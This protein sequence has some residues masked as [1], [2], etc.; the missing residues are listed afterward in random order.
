[1]PSVPNPV[2]AT[3]APEVQD[4][5][6]RSGGQSDVTPPSVKCP[7]KLRT[8]FM[9]P[10]KVRKDESTLPSLGFEPR[11]C[12]QEARCSNPVKADSLFLLQLTLSVMMAIQWLIPIS[13]RFFSTWSDHRVGGLVSSISEKYT[14]GR[15][16]IG[17]SVQ[18]S[19]YLIRD[20]LIVLTISAPPYLPYFL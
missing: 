17:I 11:T 15:K 14:F 3:L 10:L 2:H 18:I 13:L 16:S 1:M 8:H 4:Q 9:Y 5:M 19:S 20:A 6:F 12:G 7:S